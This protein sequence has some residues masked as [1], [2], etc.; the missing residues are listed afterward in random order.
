MKYFL[1]IHPLIEDLA[2]YKDIKEISYA[3]NN[4]IN[5]KKIKYKIEKIDYIINAK[6]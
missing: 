6:G 2:N 3:A 5:N 1:I 4:T